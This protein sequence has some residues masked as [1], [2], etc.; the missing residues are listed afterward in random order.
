MTLYDFVRMED[1]DFDTYDTVFDV[2]VTVCVPYDDSEIT[3]WYDKFYNFIIKHVEFKEKISECE[4]TAEWTNFITDNLEVFREVANDM[5]Y[6]DR[7]PDDNDDLIYEWIKEINSWL[8]GYVSE[9]EYQKFMEK[10]APRME[11]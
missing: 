4:C 9:V 8:A 1:T 7:V 6:D 3:E 5:W 11:D 2:E 10:Y